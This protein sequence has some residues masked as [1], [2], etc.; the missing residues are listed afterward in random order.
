MR[1][2]AGARSASAPKA[3]RTKGPGLR[4]EA[5]RKAAATRKARER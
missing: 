2:G 1:R 5:A 4:K 3:A